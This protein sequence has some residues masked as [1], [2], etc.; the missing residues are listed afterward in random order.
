MAHVS[1]ENYRTRAQLK[2]EPEAICLEATRF[3]KLGV[4]TVC[5]LCSL[6]S[7]A[8]ISTAGTGAGASVSESSTLSSRSALGIRRLPKKC[9]S[10]G[11]CANVGCIRSDVPSLHRTKPRSNLRLRVDRVGIPNRTID[12]PDEAVLVFFET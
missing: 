2:R 4:T 9:S 8:G 7:E 5:S 12:T 3:D 10:S 1:N 11:K 6:P